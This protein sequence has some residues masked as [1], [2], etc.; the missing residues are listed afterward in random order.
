MVHNANC[1][2]LRK[3]RGRGT[4]CS[5]E[6]SVGS[7]EGRSGVER[8]VGTKARLVLTRSGEGPDWS[9][10]GPDWSWQGPDWSWGGPD[11]SWQGPDWSWEGPDWSWGGPDWSWG[12]PDWSW[13]GPDWSHKRPTGLMGARLVRKERS[14]NSEA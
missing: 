10:E 11:W 7:E 6:R 14:G 3:F 9:W 5:L 13:Q 2:R 4:D 1:T 8:S 12:G